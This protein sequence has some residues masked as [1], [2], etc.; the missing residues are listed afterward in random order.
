[1][2]GTEKRSHS[3]TRTLFIPPDFFDF[4]RIFPRFSAFSAQKRPSCLLSWSPFNI[5][6][7]IT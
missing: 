7:G 2:G 4:R 3:G 1:M 6:K 5:I